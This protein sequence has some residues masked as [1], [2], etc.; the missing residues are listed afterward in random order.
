MNRE[1]TTSIRQNFSFRSNCLR[2][3]RRLY[4]LLPNR[5]DSSAKLGPQAAKD[6]G[7]PTRV[8][9]SVSSR[10]IFLDGRLN[11]KARR[12]DRKVTRRNFLRS[13]ARC[14]RPLRPIDRYATLNLVRNG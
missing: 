8:T 11:A 7:C 10:L 2:R 12:V 3:S 6:V 1:R 13:S 9:F 5:R 4:Y 14:L